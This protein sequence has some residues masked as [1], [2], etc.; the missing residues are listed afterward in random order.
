VF[1]LDEV[2][3]GQRAA[4]YS[5]RQAYLT[6]T[7]D[8]L[9]TVFKTHCHK[10][11]GEI[12]AAAAG[13]GTGSDA[14]NGGLNVEKL[15]TKALQFFPNIALDPAELTAAAAAGGPKVQSLL[16]GRLDAAIADKRA[17]VDAV[18]PWAFSSFFRYLSL[19]QTD[20]SWCK[21]LSRLD[22]LKEEMVLQSFTAER[23][24]ME[25]YKEK[26]AALFA[27]L[28]DD[29]RR[30]TV[31]SLFIYKPAPGAAVGGPGPR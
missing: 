24:V 4:V 30:N 14:A 10:T 26:A 13:T 12:Y 15:R 27:T 29:V 11:M 23:D 16:E 22:L 17:Q 3:N 1:K 9:M 8:A 2:T 25:T 18:S 20:E 6:N 21:H 5:Q 28:A 31:Y 7:D 19:V